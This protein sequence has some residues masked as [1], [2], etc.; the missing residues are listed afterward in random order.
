MTINATISMIRTGE[1]FVESFSST[2]EWLGG[3]LVRVRSGTR[4]DL[5][6]EGRNKA[7]Q[8]AAAH[9]GILITFGWA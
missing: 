8:N 3:G 9:G 2:G 5:F 7:A 1:A 6:T 4:D